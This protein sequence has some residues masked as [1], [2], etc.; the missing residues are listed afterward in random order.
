LKSIVFHSYKGGTGKTTLAANCAALLAKKGYRVFLLDFDVYAPSLHLYFGGEPKKWINEFLS[1][2]A[3]L[4]QATLDLTSIIKNRISGNA[5]VD[6]K[7]KC[8][9]LRVGFCNPEK[10]EVYKFEMVLD[11]KDKSQI[12]LFRRFV[13]LRELLLAEYAV[14]YMIIDTSPGIRYWSINALVVADVLLL[15]LKMDDLDINGTE[16]LVEE[17]YNSLTKLGAKAF[18]LWNRIQGYCV[19][20]Q[21]KETSLYRIPGATTTQNRVL[22]NHD[23][24]ARKSRSLFVTEK[25]QANE[26]DI[27]NSLSMETHINSIADIPCFCDIQFS[28]KEF[29]TVLD[30]PEHPF[31]RELERLVLAIEKV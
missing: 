18:L 14:D 22:P 24:Y 5:E 20:P 23:Q 2:N 26:T 11:K 19:P 13:L 15:T 27:K 4:K 12:K 8:G 17:I 31:T 30:Q 16:K 29:L 21:E 9:Q 10:E 28:R 1:E 25:Q 3:E 6:S 7:T